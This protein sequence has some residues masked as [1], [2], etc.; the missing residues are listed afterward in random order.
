MSH[1]QLSLQEPPTSESFLVI[2]HN[3][4]LD[5]KSLGQFIL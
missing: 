4:P 2:L 3:F 1:P 5:R